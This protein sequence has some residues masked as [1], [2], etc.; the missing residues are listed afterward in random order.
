MNDWID[1]AFALL[2]VALGCV[3]V[4]PGALE[5]GALCSTGSSGSAQ[6]WPFVVAPAL[7]VGAVSGIYSVRPLGAA[8]VGGPGDYRVLTIGVGTIHRNVCQLVLDDMSLVMNC[9][10]DID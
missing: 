4:L 9:S 5:R 2:F 8:S 3:L 6:H 10:T 1:L 7:Y